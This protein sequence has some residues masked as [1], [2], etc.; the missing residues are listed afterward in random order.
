MLVVGVGNTACDVAISLTK[1]C[2]KVY[3]SHRSGRLI[4]SRYG[5]DGL[6]ID[7]AMTWAGVRL[8]YMLE[9]FVPGLI[10]GVIH[11]ATTEKMITDA[12]RCDPAATSSS[13]QT[14]RARATEYLSNTWKLLPCPGLAFGNPTVQEDFFPALHAGDIE[15]VQGIQSFQGGNTVLLEDG[16]TIEVDAVIFATGYTFDFSIIPDVEMDTAPPGLSLQVHETNKPTASPPLPRLYQM[17]FPP[18]HASSIAFLSWMKPQENVWNVA[19]LASMAVAQIW[20]EDANANSN[21][22]AESLKSFK[23]DHQSPA[24]LPSVRDMNNEIDSY[25]QWW[26]AKHA[27]EPA[28][29]PGLIQSYPFYRFCHEKAGTGMYD[30]LDCM[31]SLRSWWLW[32]RDPELHTWL[33]QG[34]MNSY[35]WRL[36]ETNPKGISGKGRKV[37]DG[38]RQALSDAVGQ[39]LEVIAE[40]NADKVCSMR[41]F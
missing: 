3:Q 24:M 12:S 16:S 40:A 36:V 38:A 11:K 39:C 17:I 2:S 20:S 10:H 15:I 33:S 14:L 28:M 26:R 9:Y 22:S 5:D 7:T 4:L 32:F 8:K 13:P 6:P 1:C 23:D 35:A 27:K 18:K 21:V 30:L 31:G 25:L 19:E 41:I 34:P 29:H 37:W